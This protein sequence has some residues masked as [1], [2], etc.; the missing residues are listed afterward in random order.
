MG[1]VF[2][3]IAGAVIAYFGGSTFGLYDG[4]GSSAPFIAAA[5]GAVA[6]GMIGVALKP[7]QVKYNGP[8]FD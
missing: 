3:A 7:R 4:Y 5:L 2:F 8:A 1:I 6:A